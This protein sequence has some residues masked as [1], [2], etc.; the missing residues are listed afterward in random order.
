MAGGIATIR[1]CPAGTHE[2]PARPRRPQRAPLTVEDSRQQ[3]GRRR[4]DR[5]VH[6]DEPVLIVVVHEV[7][8][9]VD[10]AQD[11]RPRLSNR[12]PLYRV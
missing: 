12:L 8:N 7:L 11:D 3:S 9:R 10:V 2:A 5:D 1:R 6:E 4:R